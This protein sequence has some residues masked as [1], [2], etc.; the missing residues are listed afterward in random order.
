MGYAQKEGG[1]VREE[2][3]G[4][5]Y[6]GGIPV[7]CYHPPR[8]PTKH[9]YS[10]HWTSVVTEVFHHCNSKPNNEPQYKHIV[11]KQT[12]TRTSQECFIKDLVA[13]RQGK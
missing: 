5:R 13:R 9:K 4:E 8:S 12:V 1:R 2:G 6:L 7:A 10:H 11:T 3:G